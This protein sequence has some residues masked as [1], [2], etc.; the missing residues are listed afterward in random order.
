M[1]QL[2]FTYISRGE[3]IR[4]EELFVRSEEHPEGIHIR[5]SAIPLFDE[6]QEVVACVC[7][8]RDIS[9]AEIEMS[10]PFDEIVGKSQNMQQMFALMQRAAEVLLLCLFQ[11]KVGRVKNWSHA[12][13]T[14]IAIEKRAHLLQSIALHSRD[15]D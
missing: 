12:R 15:T 6:N 1:D 5:V 10:H 7:V 8:V 14:L 13:S 3:A 11:E 9:R 2:L 4:G